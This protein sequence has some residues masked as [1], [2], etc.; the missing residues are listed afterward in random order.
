[1]VLVILLVVLVGGAFWLSTLDTEV[2]T[3]RIEQDVTNAV[4]AR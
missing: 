4:G 2:P 3:G 1:M